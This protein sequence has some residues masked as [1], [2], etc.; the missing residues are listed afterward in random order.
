[1]PS[2]KRAIALLLSGGAGTRLWPTS[3]AECPKQFLRIFGELSLYQLTLKRLRSAGVDEVI[4]AANRD[5]KNLLTEQAIEIGEAA[6]TLIL[7]PARRDSGPAIAAGVAYARQK[8]GDETII[9]AMPCDH[10]IPDLPRFK[11]TLHSAITLAGEGYLTTFGILPTMPSNQFGYLQQGQAIAAAKGAYRVSKFHEKPKTE[12]AVQYLASGDYCWN[13]GMFVF[14]TG[15]FAAEALKHMPA[16]WEGADAA[17]KG[18][19]KRGNIVTL[20]EA[21]FLAIKPISIDHALFEHSQNVAMVRADFAWSDVGN[22][23]AVFDA[24]DKDPEG[25][26]M[27]GEAKL[28]DCKETLVISENIKVIAIGVSDL[29]IIARPGGVLVSQRNRSS[30]IKDML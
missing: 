7:E 12:L 17:A 28:R 4:V 20:A 25:N 18:S 6:P 29:V 3:R 22:W 10:L 9:C 5:H 2:K 30:E 8:F 23:S 26:A 11:S 21:P 27:Q 13:S 19:K 15:V 16:T 24:L 14:S 1:M